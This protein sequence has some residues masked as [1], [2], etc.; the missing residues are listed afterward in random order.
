MS[1]HPVPTQ[2]RDGIILKNVGQYTIT[3]NTIHS[4]HPN[5]EP[6]SYESLGKE[7]ETAHAAVTLPNGI[8]ADHADGIQVANGKGG[9]ISGNHLSIGDGTWYQAVNVH[10]E[11]DSPYKNREV[12][13]VTIK[14]N[15][16][17]NNHDFAINVQHYGAIDVERDNNAITYVFMKNRSSEEDMGVRKVRLEGKKGN[18]K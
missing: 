9:L 6:Y 7:S 17:K 11:A 4:I 14:N 2:Y 8:K 1:H 10:H 12:S 15:T 18:E 5:Y 16:I 13:P 3:G